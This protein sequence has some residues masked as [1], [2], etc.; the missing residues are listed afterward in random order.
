[1]DLPYKVKKVIEKYNLIAPKDNVLI[2]VSG[3][4]DSV[5]M[6]HILL[7]ISEKIDFKIGIAHVNHQLRGSESERDE[8]F[9]R[10]LAEGCHIPFFSER[11]DVKAYSR[12]RNLSIQ[13]GARDIRYDFFND[14]ALKHSYNKIAIAHNLD[15]QVETFLLRLIKGSGLRGLSSIPIQRDRIIRPLLFTYRHEIEEYARANSISYVEDSSNKKTYYE[16]NYIRKNIIPL[17]GRLN[18]AFKDKVISLLDDIAEVDKVFQKKATDFLNERL[19][20]DKDGLWIMIDDLMSLDTQ[21]QF[22]VICGIISQLEMSFIPLRQHM[23]LIDKIIRSR[24]PN[25]SLNLPLGMR[26]RK[27]YDRLIFTKKTLPERFNT[28]IDIH[29]GI[30]ILEPFNLILEVERYSKKDIFPFTKPIEARLSENIAFFDS[31]KIGRLSLRCF[32]EGDRFMPLGMDNMVKIKD[33]FISRKIPLE[34][35]RKTP[36]LLSGGDIIWIIGHRIDNRFR[37]TEDTLHVLKVTASA[38]P[39]QRDGQTE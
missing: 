9:V 31:D 6:F 23:Q 11:F 17:M 10:A 13:H 24:R 18:T 38:L 25:L 15:D 8:A 35:R 39:K 16:R 34:D 20:S 12:E 5:A 1:M 30:N 4:M 27:V 14:I 37:V 29:D 19:F 26:V 33:F 32:I 28:T 2:G 21:T 36:F 3:G 7:R 22:K